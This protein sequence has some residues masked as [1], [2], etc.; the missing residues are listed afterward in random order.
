MQKVQVLLTIGLMCGSLA[1]AQDSPGGQMTNPN[2]RSSAGANA[3]QGC[4]GGSNGN[5]TLT[6]DDT[7][8]VL[9][10]SGDE[11]RFQKHVGHEVAVTGKSMGNAGASSSGTSQDQS[12]ASSGVSGTSFKVSH[13]NMISKQCKSAG[14]TAQPQ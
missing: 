10:L 12:S 3:I 2:N 14:N 8:T 6:E 9:N 4:L 11:G 7:G 13:I 1:L 5:Y